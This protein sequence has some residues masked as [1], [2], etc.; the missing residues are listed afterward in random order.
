MNRFFTVFAIIVM[1]LS[2]AI[3]VFAN[4]YH[5]F[6]KED[7]LPQWPLKI[8][9]PYYITGLDYY[10]TYKSAKYPDG[11]HNGMDISVQDAEVY[12][13][14]KGTV[15]AADH[16]GD[17]GYM[18]SIR[19]NVNG[20][21]YYSRYLHLQPDSIRVAVGEE[22]SEDTVIA[23]SGGS[24]AT[25]SNDD[26]GRH[27]HLDIVRGDGDSYRDRGYTFDYFINNPSAMKNV[28]FQGV[29]E[30]TNGS[31]KSAY[32]EWI[33]Q[34]SKRVNGDFV[35]NPVDSVGTVKSE[36]PKP[37]KGKV[38]EGKDISSL[39][40]EQIPVNTGI[41]SSEQNIVAEASLPEDTS[42]D[43]MP[44]EIPEDLLKVAYSDDSS[45]DSKVYR[46]SITLDDTTASY[47]WLR[48]FVMLSGC[49]LLVFGIRF[50]LRRN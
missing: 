43:T 17:A 16:A 26:Y 45:S 5:E 42:V 1:C 33:V 38:N 9:G 34:N 4:D 11:E 39:S 35:V 10:R 40:K 29:W 46:K 15:I 36:A 27:L 6:V 30:N 12:P 22:V 49:L 19:H 32:W 14:Y 20:K 50:S 13:V 47:L 31:E 48:V 41:S 3:T 28:R 25:K 24:G 23:I 18:V 21:I 2:M 44:S 7:L 37:V 8:G